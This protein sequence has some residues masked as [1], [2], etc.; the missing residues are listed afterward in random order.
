MI[1]RASQNNTT[2][3]GKLSIAVNSSLNNFP[4]SG[5]TVSISITGGDGR[6]LEELNTNSSGQTDEVTLG[7]PPLEYS[8]EP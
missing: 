1:L 7:T 5:A 4:I 3:R 2:D 8:M 6:V